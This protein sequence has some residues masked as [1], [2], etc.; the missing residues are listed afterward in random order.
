MTAACLL[1]SLP[2][3]LWVRGATDGGVHQLQPWQQVHLPVV[4]RL[5]V[6]A[7]LRCALLDIPMFLRSCISIAVL[8]TLQQCH[9]IHVSVGLRKVADGDQAN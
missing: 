3:P 6:I 8:R 4:M 1:C 7:A 5:R 2:A 9:Q